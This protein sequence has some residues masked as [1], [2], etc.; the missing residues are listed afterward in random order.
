MTWPIAIFASFSVLVVSVMAFLA[1]VYIK[2][3]NREEKTMKEAMKSFK[4]QYSQQPMYVL[5]VPQPPK[6]KK[7]LQKDEGIY[8]ATPDKK[9]D[10]N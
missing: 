7:V 5:E 2:E 9:K 6:K 8:T 3:Y 4:D 1:L 10:I